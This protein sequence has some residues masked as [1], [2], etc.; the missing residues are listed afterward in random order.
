DFGLSFLGVTTIAAAPVL[1]KYCS[2]RRAADLYVLG[3]DDEFY[4]A[5]LPLHRVRYGW[6]DPTDLVTRE[7]PHLASLG[8]LIP[9]AE[10]LHLNE[11]MP[12][13]RNRL[14]DW[15]LDSTAAVG[16]GF[17]AQNSNELLRIIPNH[18]ESDFLVSRSILPDPAQVTT[19]RV[20]A[21]TDDFALLESKLTVARQSNAWTCQM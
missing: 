15:G 6:V 13:F 20:V 18:P 17:A 2:E 14:R 12:A 9:A 8:I 11:R 7:H 5:V 1:S 16:T 19:H 4:S 3:V 21:A 10:F